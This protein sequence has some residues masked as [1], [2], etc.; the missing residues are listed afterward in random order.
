MDLSESFATLAGYSLRV[1][2]IFESM[3]KLDDKHLTYRQSE[4][5]LSRQVGVYLENIVYAPGDGPGL[6][7]SPLSLTLPIHASLLVQGPSGCGKT[8]LVKVLSG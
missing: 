2:A 4:V 8:T 1:G 5:V 7:K 6:L 3:D